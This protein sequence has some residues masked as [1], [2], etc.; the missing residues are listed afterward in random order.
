M[1]LIIG[2]FH[3]FIM[4]YQIIYPIFFNNYF[5]DILYILFFYL[6]LLS[7]ILLEG[8]CIVTLIFKLIND[9]KYK[10]GSDIFNLKDVENIL[11]F[12]N[13]EFI[14]TIF[15]IFPIYFSFA[16]Y[17]INNRTKALPNYNFLLF[18]IC[19]LFYIS[20][21]R[22]FFNEDLFK[23]YNLEDNIIYFIILATPFL[24]Y[25]IYIYL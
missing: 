18:C 5:Y 1:E 11:P 8:E 16:L 19:Y 20:Y 2:L 7:Y 6:L 23:K 24:L 13:R 17:K 21:L 12:V 10:L 9:D 22:K 14:H 15:G 3:L 4:I 25:S